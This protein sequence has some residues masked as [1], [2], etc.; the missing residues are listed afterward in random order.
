MCRR[1]KE[2]IKSITLGMNIGE[3]I[4]IEMFKGII[5]KVYRKGVEDGFN[6]SYKNCY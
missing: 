3:I 6:W 5:L 1:D 2:V 4:L